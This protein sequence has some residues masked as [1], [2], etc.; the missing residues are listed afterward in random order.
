MD[1]KKKFG[2]FGMMQL[3]VVMVEGL[4]L[5]RELM[6]LAGVFL[7]L[8]RNF[9]CLK[10][11]LIKLF[12]Y[13]PCCLLMS[14]WKPTLSFPQAFFQLALVEIHLFEVV[15]SYF[16]KEN[17]VVAVL[18]FHQ[19]DS[20][21]SVVKELQEKLAYGQMVFEVLMFWKLKLAA[22]MINF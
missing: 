2:H 12:L 8:G 1:A 15:S 14:S 5:M 21:Y 13:W 17:L 6:V 20:D 11:G 19:I 7:V 16:Q 3:V 10:L 18:Q 4:G 22:L 9:D